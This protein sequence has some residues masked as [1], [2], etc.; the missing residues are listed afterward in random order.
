LLLAGSDRSG[1]NKD[2]N[3]DTN[4]NLIEGDASGAHSKSFDLDIEEEWGDGW[5]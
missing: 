1:I 4:G 5:E 2:N 3:V